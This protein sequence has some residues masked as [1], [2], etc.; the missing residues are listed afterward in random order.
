MGALNTVFG[1]DSYNNNTNQTPI[2]NIADK[3]IN[4]SAIVYS[5]IEKY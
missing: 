4:N 1:G 2:I 3:Q 5:H